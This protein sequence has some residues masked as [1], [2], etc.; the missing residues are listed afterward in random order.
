MVKN[1]ELPEKERC[2]F[3]DVSRKHC[4]LTSHCEIE[5]TEYTRDVTKTYNRSYHVGKDSP[6]PYYKSWENKE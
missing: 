6:A 1:K 3:S 4:T 2:V 5:I